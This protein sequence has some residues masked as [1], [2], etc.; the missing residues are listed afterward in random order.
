MIERWLQHQTL[1]RIWSVLRGLSLVAALA[2]LLAIVLLS[3]GIGATRTIL[4]EA[5]VTGITIEFSGSGEAWALPA[6]TI[7]VPLKRKLPRA[8]RGTG[9]CDQRGYSEQSGPLTVAWRKGSRVVVQRTDRQQLAL[10]VEGVPDLEDTSRIIIDQKTLRSLGALTFTGFAVLGRPIDDGQTDMI[11]SGEYEI[12]ERSPF[13]ASTEK[14]R[15][16]SLRRGETASVV[17]LSQEVPALQFGVLTL[18]EEERAVRVSMVSESGR[19]GMHLQFYGS[20]EPAVIA[21][22]WVDRALVSPTILAL[23]SGLV[24]VSSLLAI[25]RFR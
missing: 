2:F 1:T 14:I 11:L 25:P 5:S 19:I 7:C 12:R 3:A 24:V 17:D 15:I 22:S 13:L 18:D 16:G 6:A 4:T 21:P 23:V 10:T 9:I 20:G 8:Q